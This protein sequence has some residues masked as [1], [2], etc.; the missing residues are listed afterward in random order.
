MQTIQTKLAVLRRIK[1]SSTV[2]ILQAIEAKI[3][4]EKQLGDPSCCA[5]ESYR[6]HEEEKRL[7]DERVVIIWYDDKSKE[8]KWEI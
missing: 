7:D 1:A 3:I 8:W 5:A 4:T 6:T 2:S